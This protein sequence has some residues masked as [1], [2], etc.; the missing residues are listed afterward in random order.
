MTGKPITEVT[1]V[2]CNVLN[3]EFT[4]SSVGNWD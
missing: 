2:D 3:A 1:P 4:A